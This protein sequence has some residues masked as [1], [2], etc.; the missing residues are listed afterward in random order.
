[1]DAWAGRVAASP[2]TESAR[3]VPEVSRMPHAATKLA[4]SGWEDCS[5]V[6]TAGLPAAAG[7]SVGEPTT[8][9]VPMPPGATDD[10]PGEA[11]GVPGASPV[12]M[13]P[14]ATDPGPMDSDGEPGI[15]PVGMPPG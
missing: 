2:A 15:S 6:P 3:A 9:A 7:A 11:A 5:G 4:W 13:P 14:G 8:S 10:A 12:A 1:M